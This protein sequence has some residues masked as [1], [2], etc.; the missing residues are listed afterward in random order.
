MIEISVIHT[1]YK[2]MIESITRRFT[3]ERI[4]EDVV[5]SKYKKD[6]VRYIKWFVKMC[7]NNRRMCRTDK[8]T[9]GAYRSSDGDLYYGATVYVSEWYT[10]KDAIEFRHNLYHQ[11]SD[12]KIE[13]YPGVY[14]E[15]TLDIENVMAVAQEANNI[16]DT[17][18]RNNGL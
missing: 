2:Q 3:I 18:M 6:A 16:C 15:V 13:Y 8:V 10:C 11:R 12:T 1:N 5:P 7:V 17:L 14:W 4:D 9:A